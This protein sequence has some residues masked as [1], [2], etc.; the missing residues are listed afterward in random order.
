MDTDAAVNAKEPV[1]R[2]ATVMEPLPN[3]LY[4]V[5]LE[6]SSRVLA[7][8]SARHKKDFLR[9]LPGDQVEV[10]LSPLDFGRGRVVAKL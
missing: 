2:K 10:E 3:A 9:L 7:H 8:V 4:R 1:R 5:K 6:D